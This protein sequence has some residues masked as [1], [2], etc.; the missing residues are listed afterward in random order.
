MSEVNQYL[1]KKLPS[2][3]E[4]I[5][6]LCQEMLER[7]L[8]SPKDL[9]EIRNV[10]K[11]SETKIRL[12]Q[13]YQSNPPFAAS[14]CHKTQILCIFDKIKDFI[15]DRKFYEFNQAVYDIIIEIKQ[16]MDYPFFDK[17]ILDDVLKVIDQGY[18]L[19]KKSINFATKT[20]TQFLDLETLDIDSNEKD[21]AKWANLLEKFGEDFEDNIP[22]F[23]FEHF[24]YLESLCESVIVKTR[25]KTKQ[26]Y[27]KDQPKR[28]LRYAAG[29]ILNII[30]KQEEKATIE[31]AELFQDLRF[32]SQKFPI[33]L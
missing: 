20:W 2:R 19:H 24:E 28:R 10:L 21:L 27:K 18:R 6:M 23:S 29:F 13:C 9:E 25:N 14:E 33:N 26:G 5:T 22:F 30:E 15:D 12:E 16:Y 17:G 31:D 3:W 8:L 1:P 32:L 11:N 7:E 4:R